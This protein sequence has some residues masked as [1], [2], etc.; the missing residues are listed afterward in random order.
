MADKK[1]FDRAVPTT[2]SS[3]PNT[4]RIAIGDPNSLA[5][6]LTLGGLKIWLGLTGT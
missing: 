5:E 4:K 2:I 6:N 1:L 3:I